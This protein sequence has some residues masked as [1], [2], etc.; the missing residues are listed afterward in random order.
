[1]QIN[2][3]EQ[4]QRGHVLLIAGDVAVR[5]RTVQV[6][7]SANLAALSIVPVPVL[8]NS[9]V[10]SDTT[11]LD[12]A[13]DQNALLMR[14][15][16]AA[17]APGPLLIYLSG[18]LTV[19]RRGRQLYLALVGTTSATARYT[20]LPWEWLGNELRNR[21][22]GLTTVMFDLAADK[23][24]WP[25]LQEYGTLPAAT[26]AEVYGVIVPPAF[27]GEGTS[28]YTREWIKQLR[29]TSARPS[30]ARLHALTV[31][32]AALPPG[33]LVIPA[34]REVNAPPAEPDYQPPM[35][36]V[37]RLLAGDLSFLPGRRRI[38]EPPELA[39]GLEHLSPP[40]IQ[41]DEPTPEPPYPHAPTPHPAT[42]PED[43]HPAPQ[44]QS[45]LS[46]IAQHTTPPPAQGASVHPGDQPTQQLV[47]GPRPN[48]EPG[49]QQPYASVPAQPQP[50]QRPVPD[51][52]P[53]QPA[54]YETREPDPRPLIWQAAQA[55]RHDQAA[56][57]A[58][59]WEQQSLRRYGYESPQA[60]Q[61]AEIRADLARI[62][63]RWTLATQ[64]WVSATRTRLAHQAPDAPEV[65]N[66]ARGA[67]YCWNQISDAKDA[68][69]TG[70]ELM[71]L[72][73]QLPA[74]DPRHVSTAQ[75]RLQQLHNRPI[76]R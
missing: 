21:P 58:A 11:Y 3:V 72:L 1:M 70:P 31:S 44:P 47:R 48:A 39:P 55:G 23:A 71:N 6:E 43:E 25:L 68:I 33:T 28:T 75:A 8:L 76:N 20:A 64:L 45:P 13:R 66:A 51:P 27:S 32:A 46:P 15:R 7:P 17:A 56:E 16:A 34:T 18:R 22:A 19:D 62:A 5:R 67:H 2:G 57:M 4:Q 42:K 12:G 35:T 14:L 26:S 24:T 52:L 37:Q 54:P 59:A 69:E 9:T 60:T 40:P 41:L 29:S 65:L 10:P 49:P 30:N 53:Q 36:N 74:L 63:S 61:W 38:E 50:V 73:R